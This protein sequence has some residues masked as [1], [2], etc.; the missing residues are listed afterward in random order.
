[1]AADP[2]GGTKG[3]TG[4]NSSSLTT[5]TVDAAGG[6]NSGTAPAPVVASETGSSSCDRLGALADALGNAV[7]NLT[8]LVRHTISQG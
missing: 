2:S 7:S 1:M 3:Q 6:A 8:E 4:S 5:G